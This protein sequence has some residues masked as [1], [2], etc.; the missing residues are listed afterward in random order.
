MAFNYKRNVDLYFQVCSSLLVR[1]YGIGF[2]DLIMVYHHTDISYNI[3]DVYND[4]TSEKKAANIH[5]LCHHFDIFLEVFKFIFYLWSA[6]SLKHLLITLFFFL[7]K[8]HGQLMQTPCQLITFQC[9]VLW[10][11]NLIMIFVQVEC[12]LSCKSF[13]LQYFRDPD[14]FG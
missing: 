10:F 1:Y 8:F 9:T 5:H 3:W 12:E 2:T 7:N 13:S 11:D 14:F 4:D 6:S